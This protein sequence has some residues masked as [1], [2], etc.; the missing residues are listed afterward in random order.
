MSTL[1]RKRPETKT[2]QTFDVPESRFFTLASGH[3]IHQSN[4][5][6]IGV[7][8]IELFWA[9][10]SYHQ[11]KPYVATLANDLLFAGN[12]QRSEFEVVEYLD[13]LGATHRTEC[14][15]LGSSVIIRAS[16]KNIIEAFNWAVENIEAASYPD[17]ELNSAKNVRAASLE[18]QQKTPKYWSSRI[19]LESLY[20]KDYT[21]GIHGDLKDYESISRSDLLA[22][23]QAHFSLE[24]MM[25]LISGD[26]DNV[27]LD[28]ISSTLSGH[29]G[30]PITI[31]QEKFNGPLPKFD[32]PVI[33]A[34]DGT[35]QVNLTVAKHV[36]PT[37]QQERYGLTLLNLALGGF[38]GSRLMQILREEKGLTYGIGSYFKPAF[39]DYTWTIAGDLKSENATEAIAVMH[40]IFDDLKSNLLSD[41]ELN[42]IKQYYS[43]QFRGGFDGPFAMGG[44]FQHLLYR[45]LDMGYYANV[46]P[47]IWRVTAEEVRELANNYLD[48][49][50]F[51]HVLSGD[52]VKP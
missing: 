52:T 3:Q 33:H 6:N 35:N 27:I 42:K 20:G 19:S 14:G 50:S 10:G 45:G 41:N 46:L 12:D 18:R 25:V 34:V 32:Q 40:T 47:G 38:F 36:C 16:K 21:L 11:S 39:N 31:T 51:I 15:H 30:K 4:P 29:P 44:K 2:I 26:S 28:Q 9:S 37:D 5:C 8:R 49:E 22:F 17:R 43:G 7:V 13:F 1:I 23:K 24:N 48:P